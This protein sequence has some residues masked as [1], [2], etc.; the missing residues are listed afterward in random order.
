MA[1]INIYHW[2]IIKD[3]DVYNLTLPCNVSIYSGPN[4]SESI[5]SAKEQ[6]KEHMYPNI[7]LRSFR[8]G[9]IP[10]FHRHVAYP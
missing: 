7:Q 5:S 3:K 2:N 9:G 1:V 8:A 4:F 10:R 6:E